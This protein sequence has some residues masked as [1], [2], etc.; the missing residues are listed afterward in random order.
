MTVSEFGALLL[1]HKLIKSAVFF[2]VQ[3]HAKKLKI[4]LWALLQIFRLVGEVLFSPRSHVLTFEI[5]REQRHRLCECTR[6]NAESSFNNPGF[7][8]NV[9]GEIKNGSLSFA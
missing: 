3:I 2:G 4:Q 6:S 8:T 1:I 7:S 9:A 5:L